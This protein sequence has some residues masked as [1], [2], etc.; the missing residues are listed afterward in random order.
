MNSKDGTFKFYDRVLPIL[1]Q[2]EYELGINQD[3]PVGAGSMGNSPDSVSTKFEFEITGARF[4][5]SPKDVHAAYP[6]PYNEAA[7]SDKL[8]MVV[9][10]RRTLPWERNPFTGCNAGTIT[11]EEQKKF[12]Y[13]A[14]LLFTEDEL[15]QGSS[16]GESLGIRMADRRVRLV[17][18]DSANAIFSPGSHPANNS[19]SFNVKMSE[20]GL[21]GELQKSDADAIFVDALEINEY[22][23]F[24]CMPT[25]P[26]LMLTAHAK[27]VPFED[28]EQCGSDADGWFSTIISNRL[29]TEVSKKYHACLVSI[30]GRLDE[31]FVPKGY[32]KSSN[33]LLGHSRYS[34]PS[35]EQGGG[36]EIGFSIDS[37][38]EN[39]ELEEDQSNFKG[40]PLDHSEQDATP[41]GA[42]SLVDANSKSHR[43]VLLHHWTFSTSSGGSFQNIMENLGVS[44][45][46][47]ISEAVGNGYLPMTNKLRDGT[48]VNAL[49][50]GPLI[51]LS[52]KHVRKAVPYESVDECRAVVQ[53]SGGGEELSQAAAFELGRLMA[54]SDSSFVKDVIRFRKMTQREESQAQVKN[55]LGSKLLD[56]KGNAEDQSCSIRQNLTMTMAR[57]SKESEQLMQPKTSN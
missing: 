31:D 35:Q 36:F 3:I 50:R 54:I 45:L 13:L 39:A 41:V 22:D 46:G 40:K 30:E 57:F 55:Y 25:I 24:M 44:S 51:P 38:I 29:P 42:A 8:P 33:E 1:P 27:Q 56:G 37:A 12:P 26:E 53:G 17:G 2:G 32:K 6:Y 34:P 20:L 49:Y 15:K 47:S 19:I 4:S 7:Q 5:L 16:D 43:L 9:L 21:D 48:G 14:L 18:S 28:K 11:E 10:G 23:L 52:E